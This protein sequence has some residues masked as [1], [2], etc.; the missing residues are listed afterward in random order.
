MKEGG[1]DILVK[2]AA[3]KAH[4]CFMIVHISKDSWG[5]GGGFETVKEGIEVG[6]KVII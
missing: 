5:S 6:I 4:E 2:W 1:L 3:G